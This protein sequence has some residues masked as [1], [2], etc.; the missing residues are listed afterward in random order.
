MMTKKW[1]FGMPVVRSCEPVLY[2][3][4]GLYYAVVGLSDW[5]P[6]FCICVRFHNKYLADEFNGLGLPILFA[7]F[8]LFVVNAGERC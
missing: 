3:K 6:L 5:P 1:L 4:T 7:P 8:N 2:C